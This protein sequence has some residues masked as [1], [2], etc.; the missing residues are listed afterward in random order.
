MEHILQFAI[1]IDDETIKKQIEQSAEKKIVDKLR[2]DI[3][4]SIFTRWGNVSNKMEQIMA[5]VMNSYKD[6][7]INR[8]SEQVADSIKRSKKYRE[9]LAQITEDMISNDGK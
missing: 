4:A 6:E 1:N 5:D 2:E 7:I 9:A 8:A 3:K